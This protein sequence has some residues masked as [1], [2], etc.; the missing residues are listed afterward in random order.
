[1]TVLRQRMIEDL[2]LRGLATRTQEAYVAALEQLSKYYQKSPDEISEEELRQYLLYLQNEKAVSASTMT[3][4]LCGI[5]PQ[6]PTRAGTLTE[7]QK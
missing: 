7:G 6:Y 3:V 2:Q 1:M 5:K 4:A